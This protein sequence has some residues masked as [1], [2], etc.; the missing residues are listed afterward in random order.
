MHAGSRYTGHDRTLHQHSSPDTNSQLQS[1]KQQITDQK[2]VLQVDAGNMATNTVYLPGGTAMIVTGN[3]VGRIEPKGTGGDHMGRWSY[4]HL[5]QKGKA[6]LT[7][8][9]VYQVCN[10]PTNLIGH[11]AWH[12]QRLTLNQQNRTNTHPR[13]AFINNLITSVQTFQTKDHK[14]IIG[15]NFNETTDKHNS[16]IL[17]MITTTNLVDP[18]LSTHPNIPT[19]NTYTQGTQRIGAIFCSPNLIPYILSIGYAPYNWVTNSDHR[20]IFIDL[21][22]KQLFQD[23]NDTTTTMS[24]PAEPSDP[25]TNKEYPPHSLTGFT[26]T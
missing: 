23:A 7:L 12:Q 11:T 10:N 1:S 13:Q 24:H 4:V 19:F 20:A 8:Y 22:S 25:M 15:G 21:C 26:N 6:P 3:T 14:I 16:G 18:F 9:T 17:K 2:V 5:R